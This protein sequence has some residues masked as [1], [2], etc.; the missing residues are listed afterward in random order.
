MKNI[1]LLLL[2]IPIS[3]F[4]Q[5]QTT[6]ISTQPSMMS[7]GMDALNEQ[8]KSEGMFYEGEGKYIITKVGNS[9]FVS[10]KKL[11]KKCREAI[12]EF[13]NT[14]NYTSEVTNVQKF[15]QGIGVFPKV[16]ISFI[17]RN[18]DG[19]PV[20]TSEESAGNK[21]AAKKELKDLKEYLDLGIITQEEYDEKLKKLRKIILSD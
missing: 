9:G 16:S 2:F 15:K 11:E 13:S 4:G 17:V 20:V 7:K 3:I 12:K 6:I 10:L 14:N 21:E 18:S 19:T 5:D 8:K 1:L